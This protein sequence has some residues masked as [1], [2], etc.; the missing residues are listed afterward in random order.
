MK[1]STYMGMLRIL[2]CAAIFSVLWACNDGSNRSASNNNTGG[3]GSEL[4][5]NQGNWNESE[6]Q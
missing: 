6:W 4:V 5:W 3:T 2:L 1:R